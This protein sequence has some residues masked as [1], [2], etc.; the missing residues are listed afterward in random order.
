MERMARRAE[1]MKHVLAPK[2]GGLLAALEAAPE[3]DVLLVAHTGMDHVLTLR[4]VWH[5]LP[6]DKV[7]SMGW[8]RVPR[9]EIPTGRDDQIE[10]LFDWWERIDDWVEEHR[11][12]DLPPVRSA[13]QQA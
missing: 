3:A 1:R 6:M 2:P 12:T 13:R 5:S 10:W 4:D 11:P 9:E 7:I 8:W